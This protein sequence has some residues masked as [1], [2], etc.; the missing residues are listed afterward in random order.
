[1]GMLTVPG[2]SLVTTTTWP[3][4]F[5]KVAWAP[6]PF[7]MAAVGDPLLPVT[8]WTEELWVVAASRNN[9]S[10]VYKAGLE[11]RQGAM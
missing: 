7:R 5:W 9:H 1:M 6:T 8:N 4:L 10:L 3:A 11:M 2:E